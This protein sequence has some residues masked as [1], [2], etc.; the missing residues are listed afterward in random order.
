MLSS[1]VKALIEQV[2]ALIGHNHNLP[3]DKMSVAQLRF[4]LAHETMH[5]V[6]K[7]TVRDVSIWHAAMDYVIENSIGMYR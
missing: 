6:H 3:L 5:R 1:E 2:E 4:I 7:R